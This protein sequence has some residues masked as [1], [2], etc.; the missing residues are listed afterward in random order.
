MSPVPS[1]SNSCICCC[2]VFHHC[3]G[4]CC[5][6]GP[7]PSINPKKLLLDFRSIQG[8]GNGTEVFRSNFLKLNRKDIFLNNVECLSSSMILLDLRCRRSSCGNTSS[9][10]CC[11]PSM[12]PSEMK[13]QYICLLDLGRLS[14]QLQTSWDT[15][16]N[17]LVPVCNRLVPVGTGLGY[18]LEHEMRYSEQTLV[19]IVEKTKD[20]LVCLEIYIYYRH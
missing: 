17:P 11:V 6:C 8:P 14:S 19:T 15:L 13:W 4:F 16:V 3:F 9:L 7:A 2:L 1:L 5:F 10:S 20:S 12:H 18:R